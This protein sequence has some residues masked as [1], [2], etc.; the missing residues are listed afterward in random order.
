[1][2]LILA[3]GRQR[4]EGGSQSSRPS[5]ST[6]QGQPGEPGLNRETVSRE[7]KTNKQ[8]YES[9]SM[10]LFSYSKEVDK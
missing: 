2:P 9:Y 1:M 8:N 6:E 3:L 7:K 10:Q 4:Q 5:W